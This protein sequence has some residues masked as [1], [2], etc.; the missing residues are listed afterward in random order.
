[1]LRALSKLPRPALDSSALSLASLAR[2]RVASSS[3][4]R[5]Q[6][7]A[8]TSCPC[9]RLVKVAHLVHLHSQ[10]CSNDGL[11]HITRALSHPMR[12]HPRV[13]AQEELRVYAPAERRATYVSPPWHESPMPGTRCSPSSP[14]L[15]LPSCPRTTTS[16]PEHVEFR[17]GAGMSSRCRMRYRPSNALSNA[18]IAAN[19]DV[20]ALLC[21]AWCLEHWN[22]SSSA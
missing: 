4:R 18:Q 2:M 19:Q 13:L 6:R 14:R 3:S 20:I 12:G 15:Q 1:L 17:Y 16:L 7:S 8:S 22:T 21:A 9:P 10:W 5:R 11:I